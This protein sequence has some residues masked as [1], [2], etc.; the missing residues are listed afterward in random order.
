MN[1][2]IIILSN[3]D[4]NRDKKDDDELLGCRIMKGDTPLIIASFA[5]YASFIVYGASAALLGAALPEL[6]I[7]F[8]VSEKVFG[9][10]FTLR[11]TGYFAGTMASAGI[12]EIK[13]FFLS[14]QLI[15]CLA[16]ALTG[17]ANG[18]ITISKT[19]EVVF[20]MIFLQGISFG[21]IDT[22]ANCVMPELW[23]KRVQPW[24]QALHACFGIG[25]VIGPS[26]VGSLGWRSAFIVISIFSIVPVLG[27]AT[28][29]QYQ[30]H[31]NIIDNEE[32]LNEMVNDN[33]NDN[34]IKNIEETKQSNINENCVNKEVPLSIRVLIA[35]FFFFYVGLECGYGGWITTYVLE[36]NIT[37]SSSDA[38]YTSAIYWGSLTGGRIL[39]IILALF[40]KGHTMLKVQLLLTGVGCVLIITIS[41]ISY[42][43]ACIASAVIGTFN[44]AFQYYYLLF[45]LPHLQGLLFL[46]FSL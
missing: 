42:N 6:C 9:I 38:A 24:M 36:K 4:E 5:C 7:A 16:V 19:Y 10:A 39:A 23:G 18:M 41:H 35:T 31:Y 15:V 46:Q 2:E 25:S 29:L 11:G 13:K 1:N 21:F 30:S 34:E 43:N 26:V 12:L 44:L 17:F 33:D 3:E 32:N 45:T 37:E 28:L 20:C 8:D 14:K 22:F 40:M 27:L